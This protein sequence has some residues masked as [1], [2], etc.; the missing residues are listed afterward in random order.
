MRGLGISSRPFVQGSGAA[1]ISAATLLLCVRKTLLAG[2]FLLSAPCHAGPFEDATAAYRRGD[3]TTA[4]RLYQSLADQGDPRAQTN[5]GRMYLTGRGT[6]KNYPEALKLLRR[7]A[8]LGFADA[9]YN[10]GEIYLREWGVDQDLVEAARWYTRA[11]EQ[12]HVGAQ[13]T[14]AVLYMIGRGLRESKPKAAYW[15]ERAAAQGNPDAQV[16]L[17][18][19]YATGRGVSQDKVTAYKW[20]QLAQTNGRTER[21]RTKATQLLDRLSRGMSPAQIAEGQRLAREWQPV[22]ARTGQP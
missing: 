9:Q 13:F 10:L 20:L 6:G 19:I 11:A 16:E 3:Y 8:A 14:L 21:V 4:L 7:A 17:G 15:F 2:I 22:P 5:L 1:G 18:D 12:G